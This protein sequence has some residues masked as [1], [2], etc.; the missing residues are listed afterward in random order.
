M[1]ILRGSQ[2]CNQGPVVVEKKP[3][4]LMG[5]VGHEPDVDSSGEVEIFFSFL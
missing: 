4:C 1:E 2:A 3:V 5:N